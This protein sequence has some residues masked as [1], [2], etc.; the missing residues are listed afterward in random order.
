M[1]K[2]THPAATSVGFISLGCAKNLVDTQIMA[3][4][5]LED[6][7][8]LAPAPE[9]ADVVVVNTC[10]FIKDAR[11]ES[12]DAI[13][14]AC[15]LKA[16]G[17]CRAVIVAGCLPQRDRAAVTERFPAVDAVVGVDALRDLGAV[18]RRIGQGESGISEVTARSTR[19][20]DPGRRLVVLSGGP[21]AY[22]KVAE[23]CNHLCAFCAIPGIRGRYRSRPMPHVVR[24]AERLLEAGCR[25]LN[26]VSQ[27]TTAYG[28]DLPGRQRLADLIRA[29]GR[30]GGKFWIRFLYGYPTR[31]TGE[32]L[33]AMGETPGVC[34]YLDVPVQHADPAVLRA[35]RRADTVEAVA[36]LPDRVREALP[37]A[38]LRT[39]CLIGHPGETEAGF[40]RLL[41]YA[42]E[43]RFDHLGAFVFSPEDGTPAANMPGRPAAATAERRRARLLEKQWSVVR[44][45]ARRMVGQRVEVLL[46]KRDGAGRGEWV[47]RSQGQAPEV[48]GVTFVRGV[49][50]TAKAGDFAQVRITAAKDYDFDAAWVL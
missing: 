9:Q 10:A 19:L 14:S 34:R 2:S 39:T 44:E 43:S 37:G 18:I 50:P 8:V 22:L 33:A 46:E 42:E 5:L 3:G 35:M 25:E 7:L 38:A 28:A 13:R 24:E 47:A 45:T 16:A 40:R 31:V 12:A 49:P 27:D 41:R 11:D 30:I 26:L 29:L 17:R 36:K 15:D 20:F 32:L 21:Y 4:A 23:G 1:S 48:D 6:G